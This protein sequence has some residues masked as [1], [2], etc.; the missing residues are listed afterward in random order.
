MNKL[1]ESYLDKVEKGLRSLPASERADIIKE[2]QSEMTE[3]EGDGLAPD[4]IT[5]RLG[6]PKELACGYL[7][8]SIT[9]TNDFSVQKAISVLAFYGYAGISGIFLLPAAS[10]S[11]VTFAICGVLCPVAGIVKLAAFLGGRDIPQIQFVVGDYSAG[12]VALLPI[13]LAIGA[14]CLFLGWA[15][16]RLTI[17]LIRS[18]IRKKQ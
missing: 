18:L 13:S 9:K 5:A 15:L 1:L 12:P 3:L 16:W 6:D 7:G 17:A 8:D 14:V 4:A 10:I 2:I 11:A